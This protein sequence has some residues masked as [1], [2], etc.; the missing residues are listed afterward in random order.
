MTAP[1]LAAKDPPIRWGADGLVPAVAQ[2]A[3]TGQVLMV[4]FV[5]AEALAETRATAPPR[6]P[7]SGCGAPAACG[8]RWA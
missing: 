3:E 1:D 8:A 4:A 7:G 2:D 5:N 6:P